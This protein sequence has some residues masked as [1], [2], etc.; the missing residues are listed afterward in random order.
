MKPLL[1][2]GSYLS[3]YVRKVLA[4]LEVKGMAY[5]VDHIVPFFGDDRFS[6]LS[7]LRRIPVLVDGDLVL[8]GFLGD[9]PVPRG[10]AARRRRCFPRDI[11]RSGTR[12]LAGGIRRHAHGRCLH[13][14]PVQPDRHPALGVGREGRPRDGR[15]HAQGRGA[16]RARLSRERGAGRRLPLRQRL[17]VADIAIAAFFRNAGWVRFQIDA[18]R[19]PRTAGWIGRTL[20]SPPSPSWRRSRTPSCA[21]RSPSSATRSRRW[22]RR[23]APRPTP[24]PHRVVA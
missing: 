21:C 2:V 23:S 7:P 6:K 17:S 3:P 12:P 18:A 16:D 13:L 15:P 20:A 4:C 11:A 9:L 8:Y 1:I 24:A 5:E 19:W 14:A 10:Q 22:A